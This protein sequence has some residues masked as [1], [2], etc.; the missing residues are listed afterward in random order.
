MSSL[1]IYIYYIARQ[2][3]V[4]VYFKQT[5]AGL[6][7]SYSVQHGLQIYNYFANYRYVAAEIIIPNPGLVTELSNV[8]INEDL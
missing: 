4:D 3:N 8:N 6:R 1:Y 5:H 2:F 7:C